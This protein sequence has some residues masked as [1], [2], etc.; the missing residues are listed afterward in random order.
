M[1]KIQIT[2]AVFIITFVAGDFISYAEAATIRT[3][4]LWVEADSNAGKGG[5][6]QEL[7]KELKEARAALKTWKDRSD[8]FE[9]QLNNERKASKERIAELE[10]QLSQTKSVLNNVARKTKDLTKRLDQDRVARRLQVAQLESQLKVCQDVNEQKEAEI[11]NLLETNEQAL[12]ALNKAEERLAKQDLNVAGF[13]KQNMERTTESNQ[14]Q[15]TKITHV[16]WLDLKDDLDKSKYQLLVKELKQLSVIEQV[17]DLEI[18][19]FHNLNDPRAMSEYEVVM[20]MRFV[21]QDE[22]ETYQQHPKHLKLKK[23]IKKYIRSAPV[24]YDYRKE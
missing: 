9:L 13:G 15:T 24:T 3:Q 16:V 6:V 10:S 21:S 4:P 19:G 18:G 11:R 14:H 7:E 1:N 22:Y 8:D 12:E 20:S 2:L 17:H 23:S 5:I